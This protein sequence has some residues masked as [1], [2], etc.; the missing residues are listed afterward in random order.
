[1]RSVV[2][3]HFSPPVFRSGKQTHLENCTGKKDG[4]TKSI[5]NPVEALR[6][7]CGDKHS[8]LHS[9]KGSDP[10]VLGGRMKAKAR[11]SDKERRVDARAPIADEGRDKL[12]KA[13]GSRK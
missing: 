8:S 3:V 1:M 12:R 10:K 2:R 13:S 7:R 4:K 11:S 6:D 5:Q 9:P